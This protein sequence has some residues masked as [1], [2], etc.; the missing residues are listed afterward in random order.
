ML[1]LECLRF[2]SFS[3]FSFDFLNAVYSNSLITTNT[4]LQANLSHYLRLYFDY[5][6]S[7]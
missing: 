5:A 7:E 6:I 4:E 1:N 3:K 2:Q